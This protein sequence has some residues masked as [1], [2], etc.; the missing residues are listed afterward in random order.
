MGPFQ[1]HL[2]ELLI[3]LFLSITFLMSV[4]EKMI[5]WKNTLLLYN[6]HFKNTFIKNAVNFWVAFVVIVEI[7]AMLSMIYGLFNFFIYADLST[8]KVGFVIS[9]VVFLFLLIGQR[10]AK[11]YAGAMSITVYFILNIIGIYILT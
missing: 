2:T 11:D 7:V 1:T 8:L 6:D 10:I 9:S 3:A 5:D 4:F